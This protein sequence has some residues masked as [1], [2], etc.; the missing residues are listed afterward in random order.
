VPC[1]ARDCAWSLCEGCD[2]SPRGIE[3][4][5][6]GAGFG[7]VEVMSLSFWKLCEDAEFE[8]IKPVHSASKPLDNVGSLGKN[9][10]G[11]G[12]DR[13]VARVKPGRQFANGPKQRCR[14]SNSC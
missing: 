6:D 1:F 11:C 4:N 13:N 9:N 7:L 8:A 10:I 12:G 3:A 2:G 14:L 5:D